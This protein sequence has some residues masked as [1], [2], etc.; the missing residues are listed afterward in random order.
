MNFI[1]N[2]SASGQRLDK[3]LNEK[4]KN[5]SRSQIKKMIKQGLVL[6]NGQGVTVHRFLKPGDKISLSFSSKVA[7]EESAE[8]KI[9][10][11]E[12][13]FE[14]HNFI[15]LEKPAGLL[16]HPTDK[17]EKNTLVNWLSEKYPKIKQVGEQKY[18]SGIIHRLDRDVSGI[19]L[20]AKTNEAFYQLKDQFKKR[21]VKKQYLALVYGH[22]YDS[23]GEIDLPIGRSKAGKFVAHPR[24]KG[25][26][27]LDADKVAKTK[28]EVLEYIKNYTLLE[29]QILTGR[30]HQIRVH[31]SAIGHPIIGDQ[32]YKPKKK[33]FHWFQRKIKVI[34]PG[35]I[36][37]HS[38]KI[39]F[40]DLN[41]H[42]QEFESPLPKKLK[43]FL[44]GQKNQ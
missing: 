8:E 26:K 42:W 6:V 18:R 15:V 5:Y 28:Y 9:I 22:I 32:A 31:L 16:V 37:L 35:R 24:K 23:E 40:Y 19:M 27:F 33:F 17:G 39:G 21:V 44:D 10:P 36:F 30:T 43:D 11:P 13:I 7:K 1:V 38:I 12:I 3:F 41:N 25:F 14:D 34:D 20:V 4:L 2:E 29:I